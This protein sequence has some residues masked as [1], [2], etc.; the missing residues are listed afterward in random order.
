MEIKVGKT[1]RHVEGYQV[2][3]RMCIGP[4]AYLLCTAYAGSEDEVRQRAVTAA[5][6]FASLYP[7]TYS[8]ELREGV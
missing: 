7:T 3:V 6:A 1:R 8:G 5:R 2:D 4:D